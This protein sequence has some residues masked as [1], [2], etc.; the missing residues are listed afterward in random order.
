MIGTFVHESHE[1]AEFVHIFQFRSTT[2]VKIKHNTV[3]TNRDR[4]SVSRVVS[5]KAAELIHNEQ[6]EDAHLITYATE[7]PVAVQT[8]LVTMGR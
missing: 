2:F 4:N 3:A 8:P 6:C 7:L 5:V 1:L